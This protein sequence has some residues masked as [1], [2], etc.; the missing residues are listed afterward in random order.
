MH[1]VGSW[2]RCCALA[3]IG[4]AGFAF[5]ANPPAPDSPEFRSKV[6]ALAKANA[7]V[8]GVRSTA[9]E[10]AWSN[11]NLGRVRRGSGVVIG[12]GLVVTIG[13]L[14]LEADQVELLLDDDRVVPARVVAYDLASGFGLLQALTPLRAPAAALGNSSAHDP[15]DPLMIASGGAEGDMT[16]AKLVSRRAFSGYWE[17]HIDGALFTTPPRIDHSGAGLFNDK[18]ELI[19]IGSL[20]VMDAQGPDQ[21]RLPGNMFVPV[22]LLKEILPELRSRGLTRHSIRPWLG[23]NCVEVEGTVRVVK[24]SPDSPAETA[25]LSPGDMIV[26]IDGTAVRDLTGLYKVLWRGPG[27]ERD[28]TL[29]ITRNGKPETVKLRSKDRMKMLRQARGV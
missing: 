29:D 12:D 16:L 7:S 3:W 18:G 5:A 2:I 23:V 28:V 27:A 17:Y 6:E 19:G 9:V 1:K 25:G 13:Y 8:V 20:V 10:D 14:I 15:E 24:V 26:S 21:P 4:F 22:D 11:E